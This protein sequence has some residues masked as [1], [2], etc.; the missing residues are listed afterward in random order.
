LTFAKGRYPGWVLLVSVVASA[1]CGA[2]SYVSVPPSPAQA[3]GDFTVEIHRTTSERWITLSEEA[4]VAVFRVQSGRGAVVYYPYS[5][6]SEQR[7]TAGRT[8]LPGWTTEEERQYRDRSHLAF[9]DDRTSHRSFLL[10]VASPRPLRVAELMR[11]PTLLEGR[12][13]GRF[14]EASLVEGIFE[15]VVSERLA[16]PWAWAC[17]GEGLDGPTDDVGSRG[18]RRTS[19]IQRLRDEQQC[20]QRQGG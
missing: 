2:G 20:P 14:D 13:D 1:S 19:D 4:Y 5:E 11:D 6:R 17:I 8:P 16:R 7:F 3:R 10:V 18:R 15:I 9:P 12:L